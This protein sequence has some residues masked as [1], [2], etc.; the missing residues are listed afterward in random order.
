MPIEPLCRH[1]NTFEDETI[2]EASK[3]IDNPQ[4]VEGTVTVKRLIGIIRRL[5]NILIEKGSELD[6]AN[7]KISGLNAS[8]EKVRQALN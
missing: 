8:L 6:D 7:T 1:T 5:D 3:L 4:F 2:E